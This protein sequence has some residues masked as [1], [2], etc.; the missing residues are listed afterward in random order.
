MALLESP[1][2]KLWCKIGRKYSHEDTVGYGGAKTIFYV[3]VEAVPCTT[4][5]IPL[6]DEGP[7]GILPDY[8]PNQPNYLAMDKHFN[9]LVEAEKKKATGTNPDDPDEV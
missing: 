1:Y 4:K 9:D 6:S 7:P 8:N 3:P 5:Q 2:R